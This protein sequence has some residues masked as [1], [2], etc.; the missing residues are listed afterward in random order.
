MLT[1][2]PPDIEISV[3]HPD[4]CPQPQPQNFLLLFLSGHFKVATE[5]SGLT[6]DWRHLSLGVRE[7]VENPIN[8]MD[9]LLPPEK[10]TRMHG[11]A[12]DIG[13]LH[14]SL[15]PHANLSFRAMAADSENAGSLPLPLSSSEG[16]AEEPTMRGTLPVTA[17]EAEASPPLSKKAQGT[18]WK[19]V[20]LPLH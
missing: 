8:T 4:G 17:V 1:F 14:E 3:H 11:F 19:P 13:M 16:S 10:S 9:L 2:Q 6:L 20:L 18:N 15:T 7:P 12:Y 5:I